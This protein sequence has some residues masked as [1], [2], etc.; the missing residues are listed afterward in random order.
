MLKTDNHLLTYCEHIRWKLNMKE[1]N[2]SQKEDT[3]KF[4]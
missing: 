3:L 4:L 1:Q 2:N